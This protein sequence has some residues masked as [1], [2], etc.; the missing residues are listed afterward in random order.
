MLLLASQLLSIRALRMEHLWHCVY[1]DPAGERFHGDPSYL[2]KEAFAAV[3]R[4]NAITTNGHW[5][6]EP[7]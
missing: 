7:R 2:R 1:T 4:F 6:A 5:T 3:A